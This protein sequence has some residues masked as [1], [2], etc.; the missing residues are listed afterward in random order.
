MNTDTHYML[1]LNH[2]VTVNLPQAVVTHSPHSRQ[3]FTSQCSLIVSSAERAAV[4]RHPVLDW[5]VQIC[6]ESVRGDAA[7]SR[8]SFIQSYCCVTEP[9]SP[10]SPLRVSFLSSVLWPR[11]P[12]QGHKS[13]QLFFLCEERWEHV[14]KPFW[15]A[16]CS[17]SKKVTARMSPYLQ[18]CVP[19]RP[20]LL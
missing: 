12:N 19:N 1:W 8:V 2:Y 5:H 7:N 13:R 6:W 15:S 3:I 10:Q 16:P 9:T 20:L 4:C 18:G 14:Q 11:R 17:A